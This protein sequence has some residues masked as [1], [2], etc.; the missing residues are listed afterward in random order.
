M[1]CHVCVKHIF[2]L[3]FVY[4]QHMENRFCLFS[5]SLVF[6]NRIDLNQTHQFWNGIRF[7]VITVHFN[8]GRVDIDE[9]STKFII[10]F[11][12]NLFIR[13]HNTHI[14]LNFFGVCFTH[15]YGSHIVSKIQLMREKL[16]ALRRILIESLAHHQ[17]GHGE[18]TFR[19]DQSKFLWAPGDTDSP[20]IQHRYGL[21]IHHK[22]F[23]A[24]EILHYLCI[25]K[26]FIVSLL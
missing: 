10:E 23:I 15:I 1:G 17:G 19:D 5:M 9:L 24:L 14:T 11:I 18:H 12:C 13:T 16:F 6:F 4:F 2:P 7:F 3:H 22:K 26:F 21:R 8:I 20:D 25:C